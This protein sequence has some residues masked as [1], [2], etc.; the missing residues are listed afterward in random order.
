M[1]ERHLPSWLPARDPEAAVALA[2]AITQSLANLR[3]P[4]V[5][6]LTFLD[7]LDA[8]IKA[9]KEKLATTHSEYDLAPRL[10]FGAGQPLNSYL[11]RN[12][13]SALAK[14]RNRIG[15]AGL[16]QQL[17]WTSDVAEIDSAVPEILDLY[18]RRTIELNQDVSLLA[19][20]AYRRF[21]TD[22]AHAYAFDGLARLV[23]L[24]LDGMLASYAICLKWAGTVLVYSNRMAPEFGKYSAGALTNAEVVRACH[25][26]PSVDCVDWGNGIQRYKLSGD[27]TLYPYEHLDAWS[28]DSAHRAWLWTQSVRRVVRH[29]PATPVP[30]SLQG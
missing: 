26:D 27:V 1:G 5:L 13:R 11:S 24:R 23:T 15:R 20:I 6:H 25:A 8:V 19:D 30:G 7:R 16:T 2:E 3:R 10:N 4:W 22:M 18:Q 29:P 28:S 12:T 21:F 9:L 17:A 14:A